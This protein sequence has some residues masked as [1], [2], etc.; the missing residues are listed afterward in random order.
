MPRKYLSICLLIISGFVLHSQS[1]TPNL[2][3]STQWSLVNRKAISITGDKKGIQ[4]NEM[5]DAGLMIFKGGNF[6]NGTIELDIKGS[7]KMQQSFVGFAFHGK[8]LTTYDAIYF[9][10][11]N[12]KSDD[13]VR[14]SHSVQYISMPDNDWE[15]L[16]T[17]FPG[18]YESKIDPA[19]GP[20]DWFHVKI[21][22]KQKH[23]SVYVNNQSNPSLEVDKLNEN[24]TGGFGLWVGNNAAGSFANLVIAAD[25]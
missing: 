1:I 6:S 7:N 8:G 20:D 2:Q 23:I 14:R 4:L 18:K 13:A 10:P 19:P 24:Y 16:R 5:P 11:F 21:V 25:K 17:Q 9:R 22:V 12:F 15:K 3:D